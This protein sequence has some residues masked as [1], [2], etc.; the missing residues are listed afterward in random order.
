[1]KFEDLKFEPKEFTRGNQAIVWFDN[2]YGASVIDDGYGRE[3]GL[4]ELAVLDDCGVNCY[5][6]ITSDVAGYLSPED[7]TNLLERIESL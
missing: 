2:G 6:E 1:M 5:T 3:K 7:V 4:Y